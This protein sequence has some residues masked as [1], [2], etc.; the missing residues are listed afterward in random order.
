MK[1]LIE[2]TECNKKT[3]HK[4]VIETSNNGILGIGRMQWHIKNEYSC[5]TCGTVNLDALNG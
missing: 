1:I 3:L 4:H 5:L 2:C